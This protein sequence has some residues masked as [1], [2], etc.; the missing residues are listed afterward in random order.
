MAMAMEEHVSSVFPDPIHL[1]SEK[2]YQP[3]LLINKKRY[4]GRKIE[5]DNGGVSRAGW[6][7][8]SMGIET[9]RRDFCALVN[10]TLKRALHLLIMESNPEGALLYA[11]RTIDSLLRGEINLSKLI[12]SRQISRPLQDYKGNLMHINLAKRME[13]VRIG[14][15]IPFLII[16]KPKGTPAYLCAELPEKVVDEDIPVDYEYYLH[17]QLIQPLRR[18][19]YYVVK[20]R[21]VNTTLSE[22]F[23]DDP[24]SDDDDDDTPKTRKRPTLARVKDD[25]KRA[26]KDVALGKALMGDT[27]KKIHKSPAMGPMGKFLVVKSRC[28]ACKVNPA[29][30]HQSL[31]KECSGDTTTVDQQQQQDR[32]D[33]EELQT[34]IKTC[35]LICEEC[36]KTTP[37]IEIESCRNFTCPNMFDRLYNDKKLKEL[38]SRGL[39]EW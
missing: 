33:Y 12:L 14:D 30:D 28:S 29:E 17:Q 36:V 35:R 5:I 32:K 34:K 1:E 37:G 16:K 3:L 18:L 26:K 27:R 23:Q 10:E 19:F 13:N 38:K 22:F 7:I 20:G 11:Q 8:D 2:I 15:R 24:Y 31:C 21:Q 39:L 4:V 9:K 25:G 6:K